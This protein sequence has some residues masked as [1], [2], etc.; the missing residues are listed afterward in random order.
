MGTK[1]P[2]PDMGW[3]VVLAEE[4][5]K[6][7]VTIF[8]D[9]KEIALKGE[10][11]DGMANQQCEQDDKASRPPLM[12]DIEHSDGHEIHGWISGPEAMECS[13]G[14]AVR[15]FLVHP[16]QPLA[17]FRQDSSENIGARCGIGTLELFEVRTI[18]F[19]D[20][21]ECFGGDRGTRGG[22]V[23]EIDLAVLLSLELLRD[24]LD[25]HTAMLLWLDD[26]GR[27]ERGAQLR[28]TEL[29]TDAVMAQLGGAEPPCACH[30]LGH[31][32]CPDVMRPLVERVQELVGDMEPSSIRADLAALAPVISEDLLTAPSEALARLRRAGPR[33]RGRPGGVYLGP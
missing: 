13:F 4:A 2:D 25:I 7:R 17:H 19:P 14:F 31:G 5:I 15:E 20:L 29:V 24:S 11:G 27:N 26:D 9:R 21:G 18:C 33:S 22:R 16:A 6:V 30:H 10:I 12:D 1:G 3:G 8:C 28:I 32:Q 23:E